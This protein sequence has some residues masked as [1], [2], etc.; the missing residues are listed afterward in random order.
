[1]GLAEPLRSRCLMLNLEK[2]EGQRRQAETL[3]RAPAQGMDTQDSVDRPTDR[4]KV[5]L[6]KQGMDLVIQ[7]EVRPREG[8]F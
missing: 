2:S 8:W 1:M 3:S 7:T 5:S 4:K 6:Y